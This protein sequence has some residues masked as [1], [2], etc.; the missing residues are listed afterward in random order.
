MHGAQHI[1]AGLRKITYYY[2]AVPQGMT[3]VSDSRL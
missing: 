3:A 2:L 1:A